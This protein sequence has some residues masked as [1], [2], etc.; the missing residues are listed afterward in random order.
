M[1]QENRSSRRKL[2]DQKTSGVWNQIMT[3][4]AARRGTTL[5][6]L[7]VTFALIGIFMTAA[8][9]VLTSSLSAF[10]RMT[11]LGRA[12]TVSDLLLD[13]IVGEISAANLPKQNYGYSFCME[14]NDGSPWVAFDNRSSSKIAIY[15]SESSPE[16][17]IPSELGEGQLF[18]KY[19]KGAAGSNTKAVR[20][21]NWHFDSQV[22]MGY[23]IAGLT[24][25]REDKENHPNVI[26]IDLKLKNDRTGFEYETFRY[27]RCYNYDPAVANSFSIRKDKGESGLPETA[28]VFNTQT[29][30]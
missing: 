8:A 9:M 12:E 4:R 13:K 20:E 2:F 25:R 21:I 15:A 27:A 3:L 24:F 22:Y 17:Q 30:G 29:G 6:E 11:A 7:I 23:K 10:T 1:E 16:E 18:I 19:Y 14:Q 28:E 5:V 26:R